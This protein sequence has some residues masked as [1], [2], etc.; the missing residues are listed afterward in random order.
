MLMGLIVWRFAA[1]NPWTGTR[2]FRFFA[3]HAIGAIVYALVW[4]A[5]TVAEIAFYTPRAVLEV[6]IQRAAGWQ[7]LMGVLLYG[8]LAGISYLV[9][10]SNRLAEQRVLASRAELQALRAQL[11]PHFLFNTLH[12]VITLV[13]DDP[14]AAEN[15]LVRFGSLLRYALDSSR[16]GD[17]DATL[18]EEMS[19]VHGYVELEKMRA[20]ERLRIVEE[21]DP[22]TLDCVL[23]ILTLQ[24]LVENAIRHGIAPHASGGDVRI[25]AKLVNDD[26]VIAVAD[27]GGGSTMENVDAANGLGLGLVR[28]RIE[29]RFQGTGS[30]S[31]ATSPG[32][33][34]VVTLRIP[35]QTTRARRPASDVERSIPVATQTVTARA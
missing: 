12:S 32:K 13:R 15:A 11:N 27:N 6:F 22:D 8:V 28:K 31:I 23:P 3:L 25:T 5:I 1:S 17:E 7:A 34:F 9:Q 2:S 10:T 18:E 26:L 21:I 24:P 14:S 33:G 35:A 4:S 29:T 30:T 16:R 20:G 19:F